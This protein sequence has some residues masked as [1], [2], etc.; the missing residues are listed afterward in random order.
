MVNHMYWDVNIPGTVGDIKD[1]MTGEAFG[2]LAQK[3]IV[4]VD[5]SGRIWWPAES[6]PVPV[7]TSTNIGL[8]P[9]IVAFMVACIGTKF[10]VKRWRSRR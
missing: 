3:G 2:Q 7:P 9:I 5:S 8:V 1:Q 6:E 4:E 10:G